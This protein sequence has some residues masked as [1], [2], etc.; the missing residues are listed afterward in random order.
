[1]CG[2]VVNLVMAATRH[3]RKEPWRVNIAEN[4]ELWQAKVRRLAKDH[5]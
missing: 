4:K 1:M 3:E 5:S 2:D